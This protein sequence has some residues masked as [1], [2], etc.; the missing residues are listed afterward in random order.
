MRGVLV[1]ELFLEI[2]FRLVAPSQCEGLDGVEGCP[3]NDDRVV[4][5]D[6]EADTHLDPAGRFRPFL[7]PSEDERC[8]PAIPVPQCIVEKEQGDAGGEQ[9]N[10]IRNEECATAVFKSHIGEAPNIA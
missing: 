9:G 7:K 1:E 10:E 2:L 3:G 5:G 8:G 6:E 4:N